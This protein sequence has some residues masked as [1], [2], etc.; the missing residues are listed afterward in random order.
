MAKPQHGV[1]P[2]TTGPT[3]QRPSREVLRGDGR[4]NREEEDNPG[5]KRG[6]QTMAAL[7]NQSFSC[8]HCA[9]GGMA[10]RGPSRCGAGAAALLVA[11]GSEPPPAPLCLSCPLPG[12]TCVQ[13]SAAHG[14]RTAGNHIG[15]PWAVISHL[16]ACSCSKSRRGWIGCF[17]VRGCIQ[18]RR[19]I[20]ISPPSR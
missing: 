12:C 8:A 17:Q 16:H 1:P 7:R 5:I 9:A 4:K 3:A 19:K 14:S 11:M 18:Y 13:N 10:A 15:V 20:P 6:A 2:P